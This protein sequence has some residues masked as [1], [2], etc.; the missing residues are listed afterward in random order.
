MRTAVVFPAPFG[1][2]SPSTV[3]V[4]AVR[5]T[6]SSATTSPYDLTSP[7]A[8]IAAPSDT[9]PKL[10]GAGG[11]A[12]SAVPYAPMR[13]KKNRGRGSVE[14]EVLRRLLL[15]PEVVV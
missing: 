7:C 4:G 6:P 1:P 2:S 5:S 3:P 14:V 12:L 13:R 11:G 9:A 15:E 8:S 10:T